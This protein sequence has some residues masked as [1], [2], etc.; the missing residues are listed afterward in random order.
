MR[1]LLLIM[2]LFIV[3]CSPYPRYR[4]GGEEIPPEITQDVRAGF[5][6]NENLRLGFILQDYL[7]KPYRG[8]SKYEE[9]LD[10]SHF[11]Q[12]VYKR[13]NKTNLPR[14]VA[15]QF[16]SGKEVPFKLLEYGDLVFYRTERNKVS[17][18]GVFVENNSF[19]HASSSN[20]VIITNLS[21]KYWSQRYAG[22]RRVR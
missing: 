12:S 22:A 15:E 3:G 14:T 2:I 21:D 16:K 17:H 1:V 6:T 9:G 13:F 4:T 5:S 18:V 8:T 19:I 11:V 20:G 10:C 7:G